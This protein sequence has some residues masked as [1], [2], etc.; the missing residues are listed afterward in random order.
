M[1]KCEHKE[2][3][4][5]RNTAWCYAGNCI[6]QGIRKQYHI[7]STIDKLKKVTRRQDEVIKRLAELL[8]T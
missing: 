3:C 7:N 5:R 4:V 8:T 1:Y 6:F 2:Y